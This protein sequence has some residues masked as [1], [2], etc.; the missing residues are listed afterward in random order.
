MRLKVGLGVTDSAEIAAGFTALEG[1]SQASEPAVP[2]EPQHRLLFEHNPLPMMVYERATLRVIAV[3][4]AAVAG[5]GYSREEFLTLTLRDLTPAE[6]LESMERFFEA[7]LSGERPGPV[8]G[9]R[10]HRCK[11]GTIIDVEITGDD[12]ELGGRGCRIVLCQDVTERN[13]AMAEL[14]QAREQLSKR[15][16]EHR[17]LFERNPQP[18][19]VYDCETL[20]I[21]AVSDASIANTGYSRE[22]F[23]T[24]TLLDIAPEEDHAGDARIRARQRRKSDLGSSTRGRGGTVARTGRSSTSRSPAT[25]SSSAAANVACASART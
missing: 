17:L 14:V 24:M 4:N 11:D 8:S 18:M 21:V 10:R 7:N 25:T 9:A 1:R 23:L 16:E 15:A 6:D 2:S 22:E 20:R 13:R 19:L 5:Y 3:S 12:L